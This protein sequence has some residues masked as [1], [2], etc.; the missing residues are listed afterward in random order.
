[1]RSMLA[2]LSLLLLPLAQ[3]L[4]VAVP[5]AATTTKPKTT[6]SHS[7]TSSPFSAFTKSLAQE[8]K[9]PF[10]ELMKRLRSA[11]SATGATKEEK[12]KVTVG[13]DSDI[14]KL[15]GDEY[16]R[17]RGVQ[18]EQHKLH[19]ATKTATTGTA[20]AVSPPAPLIKKKATALPG[21]TTK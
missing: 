3:A 15:L 17:Y 14:H 20:P 7:H 10:M 1:M 21:T 13:L 5:S 8:K 9:K 2:L 4:P 18:Q 19:S 12:K 6:S 16:K 11:K